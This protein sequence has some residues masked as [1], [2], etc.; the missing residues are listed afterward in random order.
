M[1]GRSILTAGLLATFVSIPFTAFAQSM[2]HWV[3]SGTVKR[4]NAK[5][6]FDPGPAPTTVATARFET[7]NG[8]TTL[9]ND[10]FNAQG[11]KIHTVIV[12]QFDGK[13]HAVE[14]AA[15]PTTRI[16]KWIDD[17]TIQWITKV[18]GQLTGTTQDVL[19]RDGK[20]HTATSVGLN[21]QGQMTYNVAVWEKQ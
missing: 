8:V 12:V 2:E 18:N 6:K 11:E 19:S 10:G 20:T 3:A 21:A 9:T 4:N 16:F 15:M 17:R 1:R 7:V 13:E 5:C 14:G